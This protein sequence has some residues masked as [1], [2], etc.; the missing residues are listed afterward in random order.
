MYITGESKGELTGSILGV[1]NSLTEQIGL[2]K[3]TQKAEPESGS[4]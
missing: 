2:S 1:K 3:V 4:V